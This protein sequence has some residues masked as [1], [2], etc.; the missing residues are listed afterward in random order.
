MAKKPK[1]SPKK[2]THGLEPYWSSRWPNMDQVFDNFRK[3]MERSFASFPSFSY[4]SMSIP[5][6]PK[7]VPST[8]DVIDEGDKLRIKMDVPGVNK[9]EIDLNVT[10]NSIEISA[11]HKEK[12]EEKK[13][14]F[15]RRER[16]EVSYYRALPLSEK[17][18]SDQA[19]AKLTDGVLDV[20]IPKITPTAKPKKKSIRVQ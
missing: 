6:M 15:L 19:K 16:S 1:K 9:N 20:T 12:S 8:C 18:K 10:D 17:V 13:K 14:N 5:A 2:Q 4:P 11:K 7:M 3:D